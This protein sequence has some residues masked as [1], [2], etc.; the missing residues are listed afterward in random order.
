VNGINAAVVEVQK[1][2]NTI[3]E[4]TLKVMNLEDS[5]GSL[6]QELINKKA[7]NKLD[8]ELAFNADNEE[9]V[10]K[11]LTKENMVSLDRNEY[12]AMTKKI[13]EAEAT[14]TSTVTA[15]VAKA[16]AMAKKEAENT[17]K[18]A[19]LTQSAKEAENTAKI[20]QLESQN[21]FLKA[22]VEMWKGQLEEQRKAETERS[23]HSAVGT[24][25]V[26]STNQGR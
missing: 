17:I 1:L 5:I 16:T 24:L 10:T 22:Q 18:M 12:A 2:E 20:S 25:N 13:Q 14:L 6:Q 4:G 3:Q 23:K 19:E 26:G 9:F 11:W 21:E 15:E 8:I 7:Q